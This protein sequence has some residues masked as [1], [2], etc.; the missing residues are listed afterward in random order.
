MVAEEVGLYGEIQSSNTVNIHV[1]T[2][3]LLQAH[4]RE[5]ES[6]WAVRKLL[7]RLH[8]FTPDSLHRKMD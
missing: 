3:S 2:T 6:F 5:A 4:R 7:P 8:Q 1:V